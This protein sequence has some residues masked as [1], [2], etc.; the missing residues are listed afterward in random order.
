KNKRRG[1]LMKKSIDSWSSWNGF[2]WL[3]V[4]AHFPNSFGK[5]TGKRVTTTLSVVC[6]AAGSGRRSYARCMIEQEAKKQRGFAGCCVLWALLNGW[7][8][9]EMISGLAA[10]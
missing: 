8:N 3:L 7:R 10:P 6:Q 1:R 2:G 5:S 9:A 4:K